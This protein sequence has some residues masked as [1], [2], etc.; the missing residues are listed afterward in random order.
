VGGAKA[1]FYRFVEWLT[2]Q[3]GTAVTASSALTERRLTA[4]RRRRDTVELLP[5]GIDVERVARAAA[6]GAASGPGAPLIYAGRLLAHKRL[7]LLLRALPRLAE[8]SGGDGRLLTVFGDGPDRA[9]LEALAGSLGVAGRV[10]FRGHVQETK[11]SGASSAAPSSRSS[12]RRAKASASFRSK[13][14]PPGCR[15]S[16][17]RRARVPSTSWCATNARE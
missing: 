5:C 11:T 7:D 17:A 16:T 12:P 9:R 4:Q 13:R 3:L 2:A 10:D 8:I 14:W 15:S 1:P 6:A